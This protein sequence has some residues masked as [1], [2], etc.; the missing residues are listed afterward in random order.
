MV[1]EVGPVPLRRPGL[2]EGRHVEPLRTSRLAQLPVHRLVKKAHHLARIRVL[3]HQLDSV[4]LAL[5]R[6]QDRAE[7]DLL[8]VA[9]ETDSVELLQVHPEEGRKPLGR[10]VEV[11]RVVGGLLEIHPRQAVHD[12]RELHPPH[13]DLL[14]PRPNAAKR[15]REEVIIR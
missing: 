3:P 1:R 15:L 5:R 6:P 9:K 2:L 12:Q 7:H 8:A 11:K 14:E 10:E 13:L 4:F